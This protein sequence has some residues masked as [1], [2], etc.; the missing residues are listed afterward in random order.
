MRQCSDNKDTK[1]D[2]MSAEI[3]DLRNKRYLLDGV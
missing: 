1:Y 3:N 2:I